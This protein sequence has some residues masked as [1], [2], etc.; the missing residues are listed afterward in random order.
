MP[1]SN[2]PQLVAEVRRR[3]AGLRVL[4]V[5]AYV[6]KEAGLDLTAP[7]TAFLA[8]PYSAEQ[9]VEAVSRLLRGGEPVRVNA[10]LAS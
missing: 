3:R 10:R 7:G 9:L 4:Y 8:K 6:Q 5:S 2:G 1:R